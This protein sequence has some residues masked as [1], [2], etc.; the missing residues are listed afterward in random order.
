MNPRVDRHDLPPC[1]DRR[2]QLTAQA[3]HVL[4]HLTAALVDFGDQVDVSCVSGEH[5]VIF[6]VRVAPIDVKRL[7]GKRGRT[8]DAIRELLL[9]LG[10]KAGARYLLEIVE[11]THRV[12][13]IPLPRGNTRENHPDT[14]AD[15]TR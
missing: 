12:D 15:P 8:A 10:S 4:H 9:N 7:I 3:T 5:T 13:E 6:E 14:G 11:P 1:P 2:T